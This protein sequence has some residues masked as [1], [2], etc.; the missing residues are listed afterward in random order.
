MNLNV[1]FQLI[2]KEHNALKSVIAP[3]DQS[4]GLPL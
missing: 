2:D 3:F 1:N 4:D